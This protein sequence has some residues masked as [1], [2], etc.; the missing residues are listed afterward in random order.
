MY[1][2]NCDHPD[3]PLTILNDPEAKKFVDGSAFHL[4]TGDIS[5]LS[6]V[7]NA[8]PDK[9]LYFTEQW[10]GGNASG[11]FNGDL[12]WHLQNVII[13]S[14]RNWS[15]IVLEWNLASDPDYKP[16]TPGGCTECKGALTIGSDIRRNV[17]YYI[18][19]H[20]SKF[21]LPGSVRIASNN[22]GNL[23]SAAFHRP[24][25]KKV[26]IVLNDGGE[27]LS[28]NVKFNGKL[29]TP[30]LTAGAVATFMW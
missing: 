1:D 9:N 17:S 28:F 12:K 19:A 16:H 14:M 3:Y 22:S 10:T 18:I 27:T 15:R 6:Q 4:Y 24:D 23:Y 13:G 20:A 25:G 5:A 21:V 29:I 11:S 8:H 2:H 26:L 7:H 30:A